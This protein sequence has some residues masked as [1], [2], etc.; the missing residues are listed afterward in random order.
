MGVC[1]APIWQRAIAHFVSVSSAGK[2]RR[3]PDSEGVFANPL[4]RKAHYRSAYGGRA[5]PRRLGGDTV[6]E[7]AP[8]VHRAFF[9]IGP[10]Q[11]AAKHWLPATTHAPN[12]R[13]PTTRGSSDS[14][15]SS[16]PTWRTFRCGEVQARQMSHQVVTG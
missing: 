13:A 9:L 7:R 14:N 12:T 2:R 11:E 8:P 16:K 4:T 5:W 10:L 3:A 6:R 15:R 1:Y